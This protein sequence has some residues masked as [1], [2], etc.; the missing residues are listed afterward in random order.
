[1]RQEAAILILATLL[2]ALGLLYEVAGA[3]TA[4]AAA[5]G[6]SALRSE[7][8][9]ADQSGQSG[10]DDSGEDDDSGEESE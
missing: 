3:R 1:M 8:Q 7:V 10:S 4:A 5:T 9:T 2:T 6:I